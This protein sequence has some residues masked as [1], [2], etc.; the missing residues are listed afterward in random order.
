MSPP[1][2]K[3]WC[4]EASEMDERIFSLSL[5][6]DGD[7]CREGSGGWNGRIGTLDDSFGCWEDASKGLG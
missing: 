1:Q 5:M 4:G 3:N 6:A 7:G 2:E